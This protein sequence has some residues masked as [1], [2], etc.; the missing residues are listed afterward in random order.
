MVVTLSRIAF[1]QQQFLAARARFLDVD[2]GI[3]ARL[4]QAAVEH[5]LHVAGALEL[6]ENHLV[7]AR[8]GVDQRGGDD[9]Q[10]AG[11]LGL[12]RG[13]ENLARNFQRAGADA[14]ATSC[15]PWSRR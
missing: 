3:D 12:A 13:G 14:A 10:R 7:H 6:L 8:A 4:G 1:G 2:R 9:G 5:D 15:C 11:F